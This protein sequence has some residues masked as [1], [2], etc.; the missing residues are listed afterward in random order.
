MLFTN[1]LTFFLTN[2]FT[3]HSA[4][5]VGSLRPWRACRR[6]RACGRSGAGAGGYPLGGLRQH[7]PKRAG[8]WGWLRGGVWRMAR[9]D[10]TP[11]LGW[12]GRHCLRS[13]QCACRCRVAGLATSMANSRASEQGRWGWSA[14]SLGGRQGTLGKTAIFA[15]PTPEPL[16]CL[17]FFGCRGGYP[18]NRSNFLKISHLGSVSVSIRYAYYLTHSE[19]NRNRHQN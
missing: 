12:V 2:L 13:A 14:G 17:P 7:S 9:H 8:R 11:S 1:F 16:H 3:S 10:L 5:A 6:W 15:V 4:R 18:L 19:P